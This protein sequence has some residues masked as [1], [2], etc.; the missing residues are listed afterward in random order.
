[1]AR[2][3]IFTMSGID[4]AEAAA[5]QAEHRVLLAQRLDGREQL[6]VLLAAQPPVN[7]ARVTSTSSS[8]R[9]GRNSCSGG[10]ISR[11]MTG[12]PSIAS[13]MP[14][15]SPCCRTSS[16]PSAPCRT[17]R[18][19]PARRR[20]RRLARGGLWPWLASPGGPRGWRHGTI[21]RRSSSRN[22]CSV[23]QRP[24]PSAP[25]LTAWAASARVVGVRP[26]A[27]ARG[28]VGPAEDRRRSGSSS[29][30]AARPSAARPRRPRRSCR[31]SRLIRRLP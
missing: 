12:R 29:N 10:S 20:S 1:M 13:K 2:T 26:D 18:R 6:L 27:H 4:Q 15:K 7:S 17:W 14:S 21:G 9:L 28:L 25:K 3:C 8:S 31:R 11:M 30:R 19:P 23:R 22:M 24:M 16:L 5:A